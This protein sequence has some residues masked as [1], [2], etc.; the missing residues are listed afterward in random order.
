MASPR[1]ITVIGS[2]N[3]DL[4]TRGSRLPSAGETLIAS[5]FDTGSGGKGANQ[6]VACA[7][8]S[9][10]EGPIPNHRNEDGDWLARP[11]QV[12]MI[13]AV[14]DDTFGES[15][16]LGLEKDGIDVNRVQVKVGMKSGVACVWVEEKTGENRILIAP[17]ANYA[18]TPQMFMDLPAPR[19]DLILLQLEIPFETVLQ[20]LRTARRLNIDVLFNP[21][22]APTKAFP[23]E[24]YQ[25]VTHLIMNQSEWEAL[26]VG[27]IEPSFMQNTVLVKKFLTAF[28]SL[29]VRSV[30]VTLGAGGAYYTSQNPI[31]FGWVPA[32]TGV[33]VV[34]TTAAGDT[35]VGAYATRVAG[36]PKS[37]VGS[38]FFREAVEWASRAAAKTVE[39]AGAQSAIPYLDELE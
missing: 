31:C 34:D 13:G 24:A 25:A 35:F 18:V 10:R 26:R 39:K 33:E 36:M 5:S 22:P 23:D 32:R 15:L 12:Q 17:N 8:L 20:I 6:A 14:G 4:V 27:P 30:V 21:A 9:H 28:L 1:R 29:G 2:L 19:P 37:E 38:T 16:R 3:M 7:R 11:V